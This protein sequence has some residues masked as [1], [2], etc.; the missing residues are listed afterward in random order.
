MCKGLILGPVIVPKISINEVVAGISTADS[1]RLVNNK[2]AVSI[3]SPTGNSSPTDSSTA[4]GLSAEDPEHHA[5]ATAL[6]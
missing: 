1:S 6:P 4:R 2:S 5:A 3:G